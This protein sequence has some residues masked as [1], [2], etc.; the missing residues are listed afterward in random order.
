MEGEW[1]GGGKSIMPRAKGGRRRRGMSIALQLIKKYILI[2][3]RV[4]AVL[5]I[6]TGPVQRLQ[7]A[8]QSIG[9][10]HLRLNSEKKKTVVDAG[11][12]MYIFR[13]KTASFL[14]TACCDQFC[15]SFNKWWSLRKQL[16]ILG[17]ND[18]RREL[19]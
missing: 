3:G 6:A 12:Y 16:F 2:R 17:S 11:K 1:G 18:R 15:N 7:N 13:V 4:P 8:A 9:N 10:V 14:R 19:K 5:C